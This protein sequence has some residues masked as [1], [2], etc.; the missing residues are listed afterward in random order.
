[1]KTLTDF[2]KENEVVA[3]VQRVASLFRSFREEHPEFDSDA[4]ADLILQSHGSVRPTAETIEELSIELA[5]NGIIRAISAEE[6]LREKQ[7]MADELLAH[8]STRTFRPF[9]RD[10]WNAKVYAMTRERYYRELMSMTRAE[11]KNLVERDANRDQIVEAKLKRFPAY[12]PQ[13]CLETK[14]AWE[15]RRAAERQRLLDLRIEELEIIGANLNFVEEHKDASK[16]ALAEEAVRVDSAQHLEHVGST[17]LIPP[18]KGRERDRWE[19]VTTRQVGNNAQPVKQGEPDAYVSYSRGQ[20]VN[21]P[22]PQFRETFQVNRNGRWEYRSDALRESIT[23]V[24]NGQEPELRVTV[25][26]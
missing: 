19:P 11:L 22:L 5:R 9:E 8:C 13:I 17:P 23:K 20:L 1:M 4:S 7:S 24:L 6:Q 2:R 16:Q 12:N 25:N 21:M 26:V 3:E 10:G 15:E 18:E 14:A